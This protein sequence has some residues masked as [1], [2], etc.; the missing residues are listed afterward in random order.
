MNPF[1][2]LGIEPTDDK[3]AIR[4]AYVAETK[5]HHPD[6]GGD[7][8]HF[9]RIQQ[10]YDVLISGQWKPEPIE[11]EVRIDLVKM[12]TGCIAT[13]VFFDNNNQV[14]AAEFT[15]PAYTY[16]GNIVEFYD[17]HSTGRVIRV[18]LLETITNEWKRLDSSIVIK[19][20]INIIEANTGKNIE[21]ENFDGITHNVNVS[22]KTTADRL[23]FHITGAGFYEKNSKIRGNLTI[24]V[25]VQKEGY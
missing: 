14:M 12:Y 24:I 25:E 8:V 15:V 9:K 13:A 3:M 2:I 4:R 19:R 16:P 11:T 21:V 5:K 1:K 22:P 17:E 6:I 10:S 18:K 20:K 7:G 23:I